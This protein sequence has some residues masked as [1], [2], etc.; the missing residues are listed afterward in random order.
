MQYGKQCKLK[1]TTSKSVACSYMSLFLHPTSI[2][3]MLR[4]QVL[5][6][7]PICCPCFLEL[8]CNIAC[9][10]FRQVVP[11]E[12]PKNHTVVQAGKWQPYR[13]VTKPFEMADFYKYSTKFRNKSAIPNSTTP[14]T[15]PAQTQSHSSSSQLSPQHKGVYKP[16]KSMTC[17]LLINNSPRQCKLRPFLLLNMYENAYYI[18]TVKLCNHVSWFARSQTSCHTL[19]VNFF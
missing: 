8:L 15:E 3:K 18:S 7:N 11:F 5:D 19:L 2:V 14:G 13:E 17:Q 16:L 6:F 10:L 1:N 12:S 9:W 4:Q